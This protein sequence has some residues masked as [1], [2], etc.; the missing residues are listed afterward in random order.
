MTMNRD[1]AATSR[2]A[3]GAAVADLVVVAL[4]WLLVR[5]PY[6]AVAAGLSAFVAVVYLVRMAGGPFDPY[7]SISLL[8]WTLVSSTLLPGSI[9]GQGLAML[10]MLVVLAIS[11]SRR[12]SGWKYERFLRLAG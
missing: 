12:L 10:G 11:L 3:G 9:A 4:T 7:G 1:E 5:D 6:V 2:V 8:T